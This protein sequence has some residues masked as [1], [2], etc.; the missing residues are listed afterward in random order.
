[1]P[2][3]LLIPLIAAGV[4]AIGNIIGNAQ[5]KKQNMQLAKFQADAN[6]RYLAQQN[7]YNT[8]QAQMARYREAGLNPH[9]IYGQGSPGN[10]SSP[11]TYPNIQSTDVASTFRDVIP[12][13]TQMVMTQAQVRNIDAKTRNTYAKTEVD[14]V[15]AQLL[16]KNPL[17]DDA[18]FK[19]TIDSLKAAAELKAQDAGLRSV[20]HEVA[21]VS[22][23][24]VVEKLFKEIQLLDQRFN[25]GQQDQA[26]KAQVLKSKEFQNAILEVQKKLMIDGDV[27]PGHILQ[28]VQMLLLKMF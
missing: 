18:G 19:A 6:E 10:Q 24:H 1:M 4:S 9:L 22:A 2:F 27:T 8:P 14:K 28:F 7:A 5:Q 26:I 11:L 12:N 21:A 25:L 13:L 20:Q 3:P 17:L 16:S 23:G 15:Q